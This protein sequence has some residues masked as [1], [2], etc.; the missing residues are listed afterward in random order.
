MRCFGS[1][2]ITTRSL[3]RTSLR[4]VSSWGGRG[5]RRDVHGRG[6]WRSEWGSQLSPGGLRCIASPLWA[7]VSS[8]V[9]WG[10]WAVRVGQ[11]SMVSWPPISCDRCMG[12]GHQGAGG[13]LHSRSNTGR[14]LILFGVIGPLPLGWD[15]ESLVCPCQALIPSSPVTAGAPRLQ[16]G[17]F[18]GRGCQSV[19]L[20][21]AAR[22]ASPGRVLEMQILRLHSRL[23]N[24]TQGCAQPSGP[25]RYWGPSRSPAQ[26]CCGAPSHWPP[27]PALDRAV[28]GRLQAL[29]RVSLLQGQLSSD[30]TSRYP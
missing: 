12:T 1:H 4:L 7:S 19:A 30:C 2:G 18:P 14:V 28:E 16:P 6:A 25:S 11:A 9:K 22:A 3:Q 8:S 5:A 17:A 29:Y 20:G 27:H 13:D 15:L 21:P 23:L 10:S 24:Q 26:R